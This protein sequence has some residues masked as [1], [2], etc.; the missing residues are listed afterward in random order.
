[1]SEA[2]KLYDPSWGDKP[3]SML[4]TGE[5]DEKLKQRRLT[6]MVPLPGPMT[7][8]PLK[9]KGNKPA[10]F[11]IAKTHRLEKLPESKE[12]SPQTYDPLESLGFCASQSRLSRKSLRSERSGQSLGDGYERQV[13]NFCMA[14]KI[15][16]GVIGTTDR[17]SKPAK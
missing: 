10:T 3:K 2:L 17:F 4:K 14:P 6:L 1:M 12:P 15:K 16:G 8:S 7:Y 13:I 5:K 9:K 11:Q